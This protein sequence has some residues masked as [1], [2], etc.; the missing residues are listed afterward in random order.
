MSTVELERNMK[1][2]IVMTQPWVQLRG[3]PWEKFPRAEL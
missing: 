1:A 3:S 2:M